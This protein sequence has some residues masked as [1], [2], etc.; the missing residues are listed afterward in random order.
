MCSFDSPDPFLCH[1][2]TCFPDSFVSSGF[3]FGFTLLSFNR[4]RFWVCFSILFLMIRSD[5]RNACRRSCYRSVLCMYYFTSDCNFFGFDLPGVLK[6]KNAD[7]IVLLSG[8]VS[9]IDYWSLLTL[10]IPVISGFGSHLAWI[11]F[12]AVLCN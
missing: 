7:Y 1:Y 6:K 11:N 9:S 2:F 10:L 12:S 4:T 8:S 3:F 5:L